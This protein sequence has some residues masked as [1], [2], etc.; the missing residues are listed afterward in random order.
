MLFSTILRFFY[1]RQKY[2]VCSLTI[3][4]SAYNALISDSS[5]KRSIG[6]MFR[7]SI[8]SD[9]CMLFKFDRDSRYGI[10]MLNMNFSIDVVWLDRNRCVVDFVEG[11]EPCGSIFRCKTYT[12]RE[13][14]LYVVEFPK[15]TVKK[16]NL[17][18]GDRF[19]FEL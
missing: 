6:L 3:N 4:G 13:D 5:M 17:R 16:E 2:S 14:S 11:A 10:W 9:E 15:G 8:G 18:K 12:P 7:E 1:R 19:S